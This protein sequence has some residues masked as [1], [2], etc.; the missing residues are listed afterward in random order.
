MM[1]KI[2]RQKIRCNAKKDARKQAE[3]KDHNNNMQL[4]TNVKA[5]L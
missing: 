1:S 5:P 3:L 4:S 2:Y